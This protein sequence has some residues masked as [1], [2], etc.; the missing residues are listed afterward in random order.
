MVQNPVFM[1]PATACPNSRSDIALLVC[2]SI[3]VYRRHASA[4]RGA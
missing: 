4:E 2:S 1:A 3:N